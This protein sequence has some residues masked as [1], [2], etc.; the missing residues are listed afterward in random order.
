M[1]KILIATQNK[2]KFFVGSTYEHKKHSSSY[3]EIFSK[4]YDYII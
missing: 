4:F 3:Y 2:D 1:K